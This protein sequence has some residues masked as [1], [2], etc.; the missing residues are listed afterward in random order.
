MPFDDGFRLDDLQSRAPILPESGQGDPKQSILKS[1]GGP[2]RGP[3]ENGQL[4]AQC[5][6]FRHQFKSRRKEGE[7]K[8]KEK[9]EESHKREARSRNLDS[10]SRWVILMN[11]ACKIKSQESKGRTEISV[12]TGDAEQGK[13]VWR[14]FQPHAAGCFLRLREAVT[15]ALS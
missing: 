5:E 1:Q 15:E 12:L 6:D 9:R 8:G 11:V 4:L 7:C 10:K 2:F 13:E 14:H 3:V